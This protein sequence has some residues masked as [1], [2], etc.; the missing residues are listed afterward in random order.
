MNDNS[1]LEISENVTFLD[2]K[3]L[4]SYYNEIYSQYFDHNSGK[5]VNE[6]IE[7]K[8]IKIFEKRIELGHKKFEILPIISKDANAFNIL[9]DKSEIIKSD[10]ETLSYFNCIFNI[11][12][13]INREFNNF[14]YEIIEIKKIIDDI[15][16]GDLGD[17]ILSVRILDAFKNRY[18]DYDSHILARCLEHITKAGD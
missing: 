14:W 13:D 6:G 12:E 15:K 1:I 7:N 16:N 11:K 18:D 2:G 8:L 3:S 10:E 9:L 17:L 4:L 5:W